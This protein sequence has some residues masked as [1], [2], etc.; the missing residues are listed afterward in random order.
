M[1]NAH[2]Q[3]RLFVKKQFYYIRKKANVEISKTNVHRHDDFIL[4]ALFL[5]AMDILNQRY[6][7]FLTHLPTFRKRLVSYIY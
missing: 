1:K 5:C 7:P 4:L 2:E 3:I 6:P